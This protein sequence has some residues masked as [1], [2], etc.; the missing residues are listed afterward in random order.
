M[1]GRECCPKSGE[2]PFRHCV[3]ALKTDVVCEQWML[4]QCTK[5]FCPRRHPKLVKQQPEIVN[6]VA[7]P[8]CP[9][10]NAFKC[11][12]ECGFDDCNTHFM[13]QVALQE[14]IQR[15]REKR[16]SLTSSC[17]QVFLNSDFVYLMGLIIS[18]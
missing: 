15:G 17:W 13:E 2:C 18:F 10:H 4:K 3:A 7:P 11:T 8:R 14:H 16:I 6:K 12:G 9:S 5:I 1:G